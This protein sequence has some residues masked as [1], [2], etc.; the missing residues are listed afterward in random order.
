[1]FGML[2]DA[3]YWRSVFGLL[4]KDDVAG[5]HELAVQLG[6]GQSATGT[7]MIRMIEAEWD[8]RVRGKIL[9]ADR[10]RSIEYLPDEVPHIEGIIYK[11][12]E[13]ESDFRNRFDWHEVVPLR[14]TLLSENV[15]APWAT[16]RFGYCAQ[17]DPYYK[18]CIPY[19]AVRDEQRFGDVFVHEFAH[20]CSLSTSAARV[21]NWLGEG[22][23]VHA[24]GEHSETARSHLLR[25]PDLWL[26]RHE[27]ELRFG[28]GTELDS[29]SKWFAYQQSGWIVRFLATL[30]SEKKLLE[31]FRRFGDESFWLN[32]KFLVPSADRTADAVQH[33]YE[34]HVDEIF[35]E[36]KEGLR[37]L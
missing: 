3:T 5:A 31:L 10:S 14:V 16:A 15:D 7:S 8:V 35:A 32:V 21:P 33:V 28:P 4:V 20:V 13:L 30:Q 26:D 29:P 9:T 1:M 12:G 17:R 18:I 22:F 23:S 19:H 27:L 2:S 25:R 34:K 24:S 37:T 11:L 6:I 36:A